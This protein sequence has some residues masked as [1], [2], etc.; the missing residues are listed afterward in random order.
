MPASSF[1]QQKLRVCEVCSAYLG[2]HD[3][4]RR[5]AD[6][7]GG[8]LHLGFIQIREKLD[9][10]KVC[11]SL[12]DWTLCIKRNVWKEYPE[13][14]K[15]NWDLIGSIPFVAVY[16][17]QKAV[18]DKQEKRNQ[19]RL[20]RR[21]ER[22]KEEKMK[23]R[24]AQT[25][26]VWC[27]Y[28]PISIRLLLFHL[29]PDHAVENIKGKSLPFLHFTLTWSWW[30]TEQEAPILFLSGLALVSA[31]G[32]AL[33]QHRERGAVHARVPGRGGGGIAAD[34]PLAPEDT[35]TATST[36]PDTSKQTTRVTHLSHSGT[37]LWVFLFFSAFCD[38]WKSVE[39]KWVH[40]DS[41][42][43]NWISTWTG[44]RTLGSIVV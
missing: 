12:S 8:K 7:F 42:L 36:A 39:L 34:Q 30:A 17:E 23:K 16:L 27:I 37:C 22:E 4:D 29:E 9:Q 6:H 2:L 38:G 18:V 3:N 43:F 5:L 44:V 21:E 26:D 41:W 11:L 40:L 19:E 31:G 20:K 24:W 14:F 25:S 1:Q 33:V 15:L 32:D 28:A 13:R 10:L 35:V